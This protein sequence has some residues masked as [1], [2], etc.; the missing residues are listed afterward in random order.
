VWPWQA[1]GLSTKTLP[2]N[3]AVLRRFSPDQEIYSIDECFLDL[4]AFKR[5]NLTDYGHDICRTVLKG[6]GL[7]VRVGI[8][9]TKTLAKL[10]NHCAKK[11]PEFNGVCNFNAM[12]PEEVNLVMSETEIGDLWGVGRRLAPQLI[13]LGI[14]NVLDLK[15]ADPNR[16]RE[17]FSVV[18]E[19]AIRELN[20]VMCIE[21]EE[22]PPPK[23]QIM[24]SKSFGRPIT[25]LVQISE[26][27][28]A[29]MCRAAEKLRSQKS[30]A[31]SVHVFLRTS[32]FKPD[33]PYYS[34]AVTIPLPTATDDSRRLVNVALWALK[35]IYRPGFNYSKAGVMLGEIVPLE[36]VQTDLFSQAQSNPKSDKLM[37]AMDAINKK[38]GRSAIKVASE[39]FAKPWAMRQSNKSPCWTTKWKDLPVIED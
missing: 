33:Q 14:C 19:K 4:T 31:G 13:E 3:M 17:Q 9:S 24:S 18:M 28:T 22:V 21:M 11:R 1:L 16:L 26:A 35:K 30:A 27:V 15:N 39:G 2:R 6:L 10:A 25:E 20:G 7:P 12:S 36:G 29:Y 38:W 32:E 8:G 5:I 34:N 37:A 23:Q